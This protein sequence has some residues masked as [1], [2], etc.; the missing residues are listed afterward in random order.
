MP[1]ETGHDGRQ[2]LRNTWIYRW[3]VASWML[4][5]IILAIV[6]VA[7]AFFR[8]HAVLIPL[9]I[10]IIIGVLLEPF[11]SFQVNHHIPR[12]LAVVIT[13]ILIIAVLT[14][15]LTVIIYGISTQAANIE[16]QVKSGL[17]KIKDWFN[18]KKVTNSV[19]NWLDSSVRKAWPSIGTG[20]TRSFFNSVP[21]LAS[22]LIGLLI[23]FFMLM[24]I[25]GDDGKIKEFIAGH[26]GVPRRQGDMILDEVFASVRGYFRGTTI[27]A[28]M[29]AIVIIP[30]VLIL[31]V[32]LLGAIVLITFVTCYIPSFGGYIGGAFAVFITLASRG[33]TAGIIMLV[34]AIISHTILQNPV[35]A[36]AYGKTLNLHP[37]VALLVTLLGAA[38]AGIAGAV[39]AVPITAVVIKVVARLKAAREE[40]RIDAEGSGPEGGG[41]PRNETAVEPA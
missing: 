18:Q 29:N 24:F 9:V 33:L 20:L 7:M 31:K 37:L 34:F 13:L 8:A 19:I 39:L 17:A 21:G 1:G 15:F 12:W 30:V 35:Q 4:V 36:I 38:F 23:G 40:D 5:G 14:G 41:T 27:I 10:A 16:K 11:V 25:L 22:F 28:L 26:L 32:P 6:L 2:Q 3:G